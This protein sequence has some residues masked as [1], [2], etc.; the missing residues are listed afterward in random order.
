MTT[1]SIALARYQGQ[2]VALENVC[3][4]EGVRLGRTGAPIASWFMNKEDLGA[5]LA[6]GRDHDGPAL[7]EVMTDALLV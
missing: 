3:P 2:C 5:A 7:V 4:H 6:E 1:T